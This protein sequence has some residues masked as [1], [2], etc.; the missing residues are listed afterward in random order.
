M[1]NCWA[2]ARASCNIYIYIYIYK[3]ETET[4][5]R[6]RWST[7]HGDLHR[8][9]KVVVVVIVVVTPSQINNSHPSN[10]RNMSIWLDH[11]QRFHDDLIASHTKLTPP[12]DPLQ[13]RARS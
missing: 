3:F 2:R 6:V 10:E 1:V 4:V 13:T 7:Y 12:L 8:S 9:T 11:R 5:Q